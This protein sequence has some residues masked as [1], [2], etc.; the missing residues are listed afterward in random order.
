MRS[1]K[2]LSWNVNGIRAVEKKGFLDWLNQSGGDVVA[3][4]ET[5]ASP[6]QVSDALRAPAGWQA[7]WCAAEKKGYSGVATFS[8]LPMGQTQTGFGDARFD[9]DGRILIHELEA[10]VF[11]NIYFP[12]GGRG[13]E[14]VEHKLKFYERFLD[15]AKDYMRAGRGVIVTGDINTAFAEIDLA[16]PKENGKKSGFLPE[17]RAAVGEFFAAGLVDAYR[18]LH[19]AEQKYTWWD[20]VTRA[21][22]RNVGWRIDY[23]L[24]SQNLMSRVLSAEI[25]DDVMGSD[26]CP[27]SLTLNV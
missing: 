4:Q 18:A 14:W 5:K 25:H 22:E 20:M 21:R 10:F 6:D 17:E 26:H 3:V 15:V 9:M 11:F 13:P 27:I 8:R 2:L 24:V 16:R 1:V 19:P 12:N 7:H 23:F